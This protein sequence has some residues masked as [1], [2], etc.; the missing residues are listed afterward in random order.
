MSRALERR[1]ERL[2]RLKASNAWWLHGQCHTIM[3]DTDEELEAKEAELKASP[4][5]TE[6]DRL[7]AIRFV[8][9]VPR[10]SA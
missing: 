2:E 10:R 6:G 7:I 8:D 1:L 9:P 5:W 4:R 3:G